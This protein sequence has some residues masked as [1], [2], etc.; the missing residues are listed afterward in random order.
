MT[1]ESTFQIQSTLSASP[2]AVWQHSSAM[3][4]VNRELM[5]FMRMTH[6]AGLERID[7]QT[8]P[9]GQRLFRSYLFAFGVFP[10][11]WDDLTFE[12]IT[13]GQG[14]QEAS[15]MATA[16]V[17]RHRRWIEPHASSGGCTL[18]D[19]L[20]WVPRVAVPGA[21]FQLIVPFVFRHR[22]RKL[23]EMFGGATEP[24]A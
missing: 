22:H 5:P 2:E 11:D 20:S 1:T 16:R 21:V 9:L 7:G 12:S 17:W 19:R 14:F 24:G 15:S 6:P 10:V 8:V 18:T 3:A 4:G 13:L 23:V